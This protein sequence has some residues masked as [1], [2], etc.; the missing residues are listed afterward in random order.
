MSEDPYERYVVS[1]VRSHE[2]IRRGLDIMAKNAETIP[3]ADIYDFMQYGLAWRQNLEE[4]HNVEDKLMFPFLSAHITTT[5]LAEQHVALQ[6]L[7][8]SFKPLCTNYAANPSSYSAANF[9]SH[10]N[11]L[12]DLVLPH[13]QAEEDAFTTE[14]L[15]KAGFSNEQMTAQV[16]ALRKSGMSSGTHGSLIFMRSH[17]EPGQK[18]PRMPDPVVWGI[19]YAGG[20]VLT[21]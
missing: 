17:T 11:S 4:H 12:R 8:E 21:G 13:L 2:P 5:K 10:V 9:L 19:Y 15:R 3:P 14:S 18:F 16:E 20:W 1:L 7:L 6:W